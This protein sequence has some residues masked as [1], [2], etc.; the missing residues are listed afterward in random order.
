MNI[1]RQLLA[2]PFWILH[3]AIMLV[4]GICFWLID[5]AVFFLGNTARLIGGEPTKTREEWSEMKNGEDL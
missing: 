1:L 3:I 2:A 4:F 5:Y